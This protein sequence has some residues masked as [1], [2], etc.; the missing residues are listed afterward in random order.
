MDEI[1]LLKFYAKFLQVIG[2]KK[3]DEFSHIKND[4]DR[5]RFIYKYNSW[6][7]FIITRSCKN[8]KSAEKLKLDGNNK[9][10]TKQ[11]DQA[12]KLYNE[13]LINCPVVDCE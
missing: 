4:I 10:A 6:E 12:I 13:A 11:F 1:P 8:H 2:D 7:N 9:Y 3:K 5:I